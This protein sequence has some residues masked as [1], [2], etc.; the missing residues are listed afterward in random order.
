MRKIKNRDPETIAV[1]TGEKLKGIAYLMNNFKRHSSNS[2]AESEAWSGIS[3]IL[4]D[5][6][7]E[8]YSA[9]DALQEERRTSKVNA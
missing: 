8:L 5:L 4:E 2:E 1:F 7:D 9:A 3:L 6:G